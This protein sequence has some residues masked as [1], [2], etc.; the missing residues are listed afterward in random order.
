MP[1]MATIM[2]KR[3][4]EIQVHYW[5]GWDGYPNGNIID[6]MESKIDLSI[7]FIP[8]CTLAWS[9]S[10]NCKKERDIAAFQN[11]YNELNNSTF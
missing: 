1:E 7:V 8:I 3:H 6:F 11:I 2:M 4:P 9:K 10:Q 5:E